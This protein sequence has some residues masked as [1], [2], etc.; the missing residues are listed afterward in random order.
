MAGLQGHRGTGFQGHRVPELQ[1]YRVTRL[2]GYR[3]YRVAGLQDRGTGVQGSSVAGQEQRYRGTGFQ[4]YRGTGLQGATVT[5]GL[6]GS[7]VSRFQGPRTGYRAAGLQG[8]RVPRLQGRVPR[9][10]GYR[11]QRYSVAGLQ[12]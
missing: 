3:V 7:R 6:Q 12:G 2:E 1:G 10:Q 9:L 8:N 4:A 11:V 5:L